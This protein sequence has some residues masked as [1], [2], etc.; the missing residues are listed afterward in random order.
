[1][2]CMFTPW[3]QDIRDV[4]ISLSPAH[5]ALDL[6]WASLDL[7][8][9]QF[10]HDM[11]IWVYLNQKFSHPLSIYWIL[12]FV[13]CFY[14]MSSKSLSYQFY[15]FPFHFWKRTLA[16]IICIFSYSCK[17]CSANVLLKY[18]NIDS[19]HSSYCSW[20]K[21]KAYR[22]FPLIYNVFAMNSYQ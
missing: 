12:C 7:I 6:I 17:F 15:K 5:S 20:K 2:C 1:M 21:R 13:F 14:E 11:F 9:L 10:M 19:K 4:F 22:S 8:Y 18:T 3:Y 16:L